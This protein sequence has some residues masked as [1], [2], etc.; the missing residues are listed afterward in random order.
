M[1]FIPMS[2]IEK[3]KDDVGPSIWL[4]AEFNVRTL[5]VK[6]PALPATI[7][8]SSSLIVVPAETLTGFFTLYVKVEPD[9]EN[10]PKPIP[11]LSIN[12]VAN[13]RSKLGGK[14]ISIV[15]IVAVVAVF[16]NMS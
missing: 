13:V 1:S 6:L 3:K 11:Y 15:F 7:L 12:L 4:F 16:K 14:V 5:T 2:F 9:A 10:E 8:A